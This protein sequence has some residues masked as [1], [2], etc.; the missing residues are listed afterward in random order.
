[1]NEWLSEQRQPIFVLLLGSYDP[2]TKVLM[3]AV[4]R[5]IAENFGGQGIFPFLLEELEVYRYDNY[6]MLVERWSDRVA[7]LHIFTHQGLL[8]ETHELQ[9]KDGNLHQA[10]LD[11]LREKYG[12]YYAERMPVLEKLATVAKTFPA[13]LLIRDHQ[14]TRGGELIELTYCIMIGTP[15][16]RIRLFYRSN[17]VISQMVMEILDA[18]GI[19]TRPYNSETE[20]ITSVIRFLYYKIIKAGTDESLSSKKDD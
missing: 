14:E 18:S 13:I 12:F 16:E 11:L 7:S 5:G 6:F 2:E 4:K 19:I 9:L 1:M 8:E 3:D 20:L 10:V 17:V 15:V